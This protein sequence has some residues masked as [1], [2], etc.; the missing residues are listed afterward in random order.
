MIWICTIYE[1]EPT[2]EMEFNSAK[3]RDFVKPMW[4]KAGKFTKGVKHMN[5]EDTDEVRMRNIYL[6][7]VPENDWLLILDSDEIVFGALE[8]L[9]QIVRQLAEKGSISAFIAEYR[10][11]QSILRI[12]LSV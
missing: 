2:V 11:D 8:L 4:I 7:Q 1:D 12:L 6:E 9:P 5:I 3:L 10:V